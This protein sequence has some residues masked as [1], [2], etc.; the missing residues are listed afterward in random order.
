MYTH[1]CMYVYIY[2]H[3][4]EYCTVLYIYMYMDYM[5]I[6]MITQYVYTRYIYIYIYD[7]HIQLYGYMRLNQVDSNFTIK[8]LQLMCTSKLHFDTANLTTLPAF[9]KQFISLPTVLQQ[10]SVLRTGRPRLVC[11]FHAR[12][13]AQ[14]RFYHGA[15][16]TRLS[17][18]DVTRFYLTAFGGFGHHGKSHP[19]RKQRL[20][21]PSKNMV[22][23]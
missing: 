21:R 10:F 13:A 16:K 15:N 3:I 14:S 20:H 23:V 2:I 11:S 19:G 9:L 6:C 8:R 12:G 22:F 7:M 5:Y 4:R 18:S 1:D 17:G